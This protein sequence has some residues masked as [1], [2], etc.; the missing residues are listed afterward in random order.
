MGQ[1]PGEIRRDIEQTRRDMSATLDAI[2]YKLDIPARV[3]YRATTMWGGMSDALFGAKEETK[4]AARDVMSSATNV[5]E[6]AEHRLESVTSNL[7][8]GLSEV[9]EKVVD[10]MTSGASS[11][12]E[13]AKSRASSAGSFLKENALLVGV[14]AFAV[15]LVAG[16]LIPRTRV[17]EEKIAPV[18]HEW[19]SKA[20]ESGE[21]AINKAMDS[22]KESIGEK[23]VDKGK[24]MTHEAM[25]AM[26][27][28]SSSQRQSMNEPPRQPGQ[29]M[30]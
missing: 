25:Q 29:E 23:V 9:K 18:A 3:R 17:E 10:T 20:M 16:M 28:E 2:G 13:M 4:E 15:A 27:G 21:K 24:E 8:T 7:Q 26:G 1:T 30:R 22:T 19:R 14:G 12:G 5:V 6:M 11:T